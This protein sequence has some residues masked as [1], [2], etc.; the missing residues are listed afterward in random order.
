M[1]V[2]GLG[3]K[4]ACVGSLVSALVAGAGPA[5]AESG[6]YLTKPASEVAA[7]PA[8]P[9]TYLCIFNSD[10]DMRAYNKCGVINAVPDTWWGIGSYYNSQASGRRATFYDYNGSYHSMSCAALCSVPV[11]PDWT[12][13]RYV[14]AC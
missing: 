6:G 2:K 8:C 12:V 11:G 13:V 4:M 5:S 3:I 9:Y 7:T 1:D 10:G 14:R